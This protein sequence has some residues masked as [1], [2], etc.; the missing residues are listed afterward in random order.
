LLPAR[1]TGRGLGGFGHL[2]QYT[3]IKSAPGFSYHRDVPNRFTGF[4][5]FA[6][7]QVK[8]KLLGEKDVC[9]LDE[10]QRSESRNRSAAQS[11]PHDHAGQHIAQ[12]VHTQ[13]DAGHRNA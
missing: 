5:R 9:L 3:A 13:H 11:N 2:P 8:R 4:E 12:K 7:T 10:S 6:E 1:N